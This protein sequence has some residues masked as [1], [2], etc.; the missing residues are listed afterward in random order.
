MTGLPLARLRDDSIHDS[1]SS[2]AVHMEEEA[3][4]VLVRESSNS[5]NAILAEGK[6]K[7]KYVVPHRLMCLS[8]IVFVF[9]LV[10][11]IDSVNRVYRVQLELGAAAGKD[12]A[13]AQ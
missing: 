10:L 7:T 8:Q 1:R 4:Y 11:F 9:V 3:L 5:K 2:H 13:V 6:L 12:G